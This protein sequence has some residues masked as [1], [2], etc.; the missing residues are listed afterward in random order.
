M[1]HVLLRPPRA[2]GPSWLRVRAVTPDP[3]DDCSRAQVMP[4]TSTGIQ[5]HAPVGVGRRRAVSASSIIGSFARSGLQDPLRAGDRMALGT[6]T[7]FRRSTH[8]HH[9]VVTETVRARRRTGAHSARRPRHRAARRPRGPWNRPAQQRPP[10]HAAGDDSRA[11]RSARVP[12]PS[13][14]EAAP[15]AAA[16]HRRSGRRPPWSGRSEA[17]ADANSESSAPSRCA[18]AAQPAALVR[19]WSAS[20]VVSHDAPLAALPGRGHRHSPRGGASP[21]QPRAHTSAAMVKGSDRRVDDD[22]RARVCVSSS[23]VSIDGT[24]SHAS[25]TRDSDRQ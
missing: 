22:L 2:G 9:V 4:D 24:A 15:S 16:K 20:A 5:R 12:P 7:M 17:P 18:M 19:R 8:T 6:G 25:V 10:V 3:S 23:E 1:A 14:R 11:P 21:I 13:A